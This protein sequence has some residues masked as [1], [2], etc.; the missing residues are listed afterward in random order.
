ML[1]VVDDQFMTVADPGG[2][3]IDF[4]FL[5]PLHSTDSGSATGKFKNE[6]VGLP[7]NSTYSGLCNSRSICD[8]EK[9]RK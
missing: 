9:T 2:S 7:N 8:S 5:A 3:H 1:E 6:K 4:M